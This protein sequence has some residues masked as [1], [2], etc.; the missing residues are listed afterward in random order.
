MLKRKRN[1]AER[2]V[3]ERFHGFRQAGRGGKGEN[4]PD[5]T[6]KQAFFKNRCSPYS[7][8]GVRK[9]ASPN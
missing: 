5:D 8:Q 1:A 2:K 4:Q 3:A 7:E 9:S 6:T